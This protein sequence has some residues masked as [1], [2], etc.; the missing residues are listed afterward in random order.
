[1]TAV[2]ATESMAQLAKRVDDHLPAVLAELEGLIRIPSVSSDPDHAADV[3]RSAETTAAVLARLGLESEVVTAGGLPSVIA[4]RSGPPG[5]P[6]VLLYA[7]HDVQPPG[8]RTDWQSE[9]FEPVCRHGRLFGRGAADDKAGLAVHLAALLA[10]GPGLPVGVTVLVEG[11]EE[12]GSPTLEALVRQRHDQLAADVIVIADSVNWAVGVPSLTV[13]LRGLV[14]LVVEVRTLEHPLHSG[15]WGGPV[16][17]ALTTLIATLAALHDPD[18]SVAVP[19]LVTRTGSDVEYDEGR[20]RADAG[21]LEG[22]HLTGAGSIT[23]RL[24]N[25][26]TATVTAVDAPRVAD[27]ANVLSAV[28]RA[29]LSVRLA[30][31]DDPER[32]LAA[33]TDH[34]RRSVPHGADLTITPGASAHP[35][36]VRAPDGVREAALA[37]LRTAWGGTEPVE[38]GVGGTLPLI[39]LFTDAFP[40]AAVLV[41]GVEDPD[42]RAHGPDES[43]HLADFRNGCVAE[44]LLLQLL[45]DVSA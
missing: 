13:S 21:L 7:H 24:W 4:R 10:H 16:P 17:D 26:P 15:A 38:I 1:M 32:A 3:W 9:P 41:T 39:K 36:Q 29:K 18:G 6:T 14:D 23:D 27:A 2:T 20:F 37:A 11:E 43:L 12:I 5:A 31:G 35:S 44:A 8:A 28:A 40:T 45:A 19:G 34:L 33:I 25:Q 42:T 30:P 22:V